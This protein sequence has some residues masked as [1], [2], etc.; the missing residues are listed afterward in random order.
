MGFN[1]FILF[2]CQASN[3]IDNFLRNPDFPDVVQE[4]HLINFVL[5]LAPF[6][7]SPRNL[8]SV[9]GHP[10]RMSHRVRILGVDGLS[11]G[12][13]HLLK[14]FFTVGAALFRQR[15]LALYFVFEMPLQIIKL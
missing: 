10:L 3:F 7:A 6:A 1:D 8:T 14:H 13:H 12:Q 15:G 4:T 2:L 5:P 11:Q 9:G